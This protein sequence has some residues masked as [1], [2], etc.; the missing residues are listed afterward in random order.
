MREQAL[1]QLGK[2]LAGAARLSQSS[3]ARSCQH[4]EGPGWFEGA[5]PRAARKSEGG[6]LPIGGDTGSSGRAPGRMKPRRGTGSRRAEQ[7]TVERG[8]P[9]REA[10]RTRPRNAR[11]IVRSWRRTSR[12]RRRPNVAEVSDPRKGV[13]AVRE[14]QT[15]EGRSPGALRDETGPGGLAGRKP[16]RGSKPWGRNVAGPGNPAQ[17]DPRTRH[18]LKGTEPHERRV[19]KHGP[20]GR[21]ATGD[22]G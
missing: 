6:W 15:P 13:T 21:L 3:Q 20:R 16:P 17:V 12:I 10:S 5:S 1:S 14:E 19:A 18:V 9:G 2:N 7:A 22:L 11:P 8:L 4:P